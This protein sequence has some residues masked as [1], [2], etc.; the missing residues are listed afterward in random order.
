MA[1]GPCLWPENLSLPDWSVILSPHEGKNHVEHKRAGKRESSDDGDRREVHG[2]RGR[3]ACSANGHRF[4]RRLP[5][6][7]RVSIPACPTPPG[8][9]CK[10]GSAK[11]PAA[12]LPHLPVG[13]AY[14]VIR[15]DI[16][17]QRPVHG[18]AILHRS[19]ATVRLR[20]GRLPVRHHCTNI[21]IVCSA[22]AYSYGE[23]II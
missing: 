14:A 8:C 9:G 21:D 18:G 11:S 16:A 2:Q 22:C 15:G 1:R 10:G 12:A 4:S 19:S 3:P 13:D 23:Q 5:A 6:R 17:H 20:D 7:T